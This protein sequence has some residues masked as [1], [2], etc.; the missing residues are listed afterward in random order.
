[1]LE[2]LFGD[3]NLSLEKLS[4]NIHKLD[5]GIGIIESSIAKVESALHVFASTL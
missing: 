5:E 4:G 1:M 3:P 2:D